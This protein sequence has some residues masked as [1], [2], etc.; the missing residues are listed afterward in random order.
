MLI[1]ADG[2]AFGPEMDR[3]M[4][5]IKRKAGIVLYLP[6][7]FEWLIL[8]SGVISFPSLKLI[9]EK[10]ENYIESSRYFS[11]ERFFT[12]LLI[13]ITKDTYLKYAKRK[14]N[15]VYLHT[16]IAAQIVRQITGIE[17]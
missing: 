9:L 10:P 3:I 7:S 13:S 2:A 14:L 17:L 1:I 16:D 6:E 11:W 4:K 12:D 5:Q 15:E 8:G